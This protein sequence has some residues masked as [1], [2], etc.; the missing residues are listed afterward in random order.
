MPE[1]PQS[2]SLCGCIWNCC[3][4]GGN[5]EGRL[6]QP[7]CW[8]YS[9]A[10]SSL[11]S[12][13]VDPILFLYGYRKMPSMKEVMISRC[14]SDTDPVEFILTDFII[15]KCL[16]YWKN[17]PDLIFCYPPCPI[18]IKSCL[19]WKEYIRLSLIQSRLYLEQRCESIRVRGRVW[20][21]AQ[22]FF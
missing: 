8:L 12:L 11:R 1:P 14:N 4:R 13:E 21:N 6:I 19:E 20:P 16:E 5:S 2:I 17:S 22:V 9:P 15:L 3:S 7:C 10:F 18:K